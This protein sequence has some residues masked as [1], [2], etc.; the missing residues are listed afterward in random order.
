MYPFE[1][2]SK[3]YVSRS[4]PTYKSDWPFTDLKKRE[5]KATFAVGFAVA[6]LISEKQVISLLLL[7]QIAIFEWCR[8]H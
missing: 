3:I 2:E 6:R 4:F 7:Y 5:L 1:I 8:I